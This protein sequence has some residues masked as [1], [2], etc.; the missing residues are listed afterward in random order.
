MDDIVPFAGQVWWSM[1]AV[2]SFSRAADLFS[3]WVATPSLLLE[4]NPIARWLG[5][6]GAIPVNGLLCL[7]FAFFPLPAIILSTTSTLVAARNFQQAWLMRSYGE[8][9]YRDWHVQR[10]QEVPYAL[11]LGCLG[12]QNFLVGA[13]GVVLAWSAMVGKDILIVPFGIGAGIVAYAITVTFYSLLAVRGIR[14]AMT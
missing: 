4:A 8:M 7:G 9:N 5:W 3:T 2:L 14:R 1:L 10:L 12:L 6:R 11:F 13:V